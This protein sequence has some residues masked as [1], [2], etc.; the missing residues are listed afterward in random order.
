MDNKCNL[1]SQYAYIDGQQI[2]INDYETN[3]LDRKNDLYC[4]FGHKL[5]AVIN[6]SVRKAHF[7]HDYIHYTSDMCEW[8]YNWQSE[9]ELTEVVFNKINDQ[10]KDRRADVYIRSHNL[11]LEFQ[12]SCISKE[13]V[14]NRKNDYGL[15]GA[16]IIWVIDGNT[17]IEKTEL[18]NNRIFLTF[19]TTWLYDS[20]TSYDIIYIDYDGYIYKLYP[21]HVKNKMIDVSKPYYRNEFIQ[22]IN[23][24]NS[25]LH[26]IDIPEQCTLYISQLGAGNGK[27]YSIIQKLESD[28]FSHY[29]QYI[30][31]TKQHSAKEIIYKEFKEQINRGDLKF[32]T[33]LQ[34]LNENTIKKDKK[35]ILSYDIKNLK[36]EIVICTIDSLMYKLGNTCANGTDMFTTIIQSIIDDYIQKNNINDFKYGQVRVKLNKEV[37]VIIDETQ[38]LPESYANAVIKLMRSRYVDAFVLGDKLQSISYEHNAFNYFENEFPYINRICTK[39]INKCRR[40]INKTLIDFCNSVIIFDKYNLPIIEPYKNED[41]Q[42]PTQTLELIKCECSHKDRS[43]INDNVDKIMDK[44]IF[45]VENNNCQPNDFLFVTPFTKNNEMVEAIELAINTYWTKKNNN[46]EYIRYALFH[47]SEE[48]SSIDTKLSKNATR[49]VS[50]HCAKGD[51]RKIVFV[52]GCDEQSLKKF[53]KGVIN[54][55]Y[56]SLF[57]VAITRMKDKL[58]FA[59]IANNDD[60]HQRITKFSIANNIEIIPSIILTNEIKY[61]D[62]INTDTND[63]VFDFLKENI[64]QNCNFDKC[65]GDDEK[66][67]IDMQHHNIRYVCMHIAFWL[68]IIIK[69]EQNKN[70][71]KA[72]FCKIICSNTSVCVSWKEYNNKLSDNCEYNRQFGN[73]E[74]RNLCILQYDDRDSRCKIYYEIIMKYIELVKQ[75]LNKILDFK[76]NYLCPYES[77]ILYYMYNICEYGIRAHDLNI[78]ELYEVTHIYYTSFKHNIGKH[79]ECYCK[80]IFPNN[81]NNGVLYKYLFEHYEKIS[82]LNV[83]YDKFLESNHNINVLLSH[84]FEYKG[85]NNDY[86]IK[87]S[88]FIGYNDDVVYNIYIRPSFNKLN[89]NKSLIESMYDTYFIQNRKSPKDNEKINGKKIRTI[90]FSCDMDKHYIFDWSNE[91]DYIMKNELYFK[92]RIYEYMINLYISQIKNYHTHISYK[93][94]ESKELHT[95]RKIKN[96]IDDLDQNDTISNHFIIKYLDEIKRKISRCKNEQK[97]YNIIKEDLL[98][99]ENFSATIKSDIIFSINDY[100]GI[101]NEY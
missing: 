12:H 33:N 21:S 43:K 42:L 41:M 40:F 16:N 87:K 92:H 20:F 52:V 69:N 44:Y 77:I 15:H 39:P 89:N 63:D 14:D 46:T 5:I 26:N 7:R 62:I 65:V 56:D 1:N 72:I 10:I 8:H 47:K 83:E 18:D 93:F 31:V 97:I 50:I 38:D 73:K 55:I 28:D 74:K 53:S 36:R 19:N 101:N 6:V 75:K 2:Q 27:T 76:I 25:E 48:G 98:D 64:L 85:T 30:I 32:I 35:Y 13:E 79:T 54:L 17:H 59:Y 49:I 80:K 71:L 11:V 68:K 37:C 60:I 23:E 100:L 58:Y 70:Q 86:K 95:V 57:H 45:E 24:N 22:I 66:Q 90:L 96:I 29:K 84:S 34:I 9:F 94:N 78:T 82:I 67:I 99:Y 51:G 3:F 4:F 88:L 91:I 81:N 61:D